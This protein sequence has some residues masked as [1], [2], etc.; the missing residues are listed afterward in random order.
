MPK[1]RAAL[2][3]EWH[4]ITPQN[5]LCP[6]LPTTTQTRLQLSSTSVAPG[7]HLSQRYR[8]QRSTDFYTELSGLAPFCTAELT[9]FVGKPDTT[10]TLF[11]KIQQW[12][13]WCPSKACWRIIQHN[14]RWWRRGRGPGLAWSPA[15]LCCRAGCY[16]DEMTVKNWRSWSDTPPHSLSWKPC[17]W[18]CVCQSSLSHLRCG[19]GNLSGCGSSNAFRQDRSSP[20]V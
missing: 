9:Q 18:H 17:V 2:K 1:H 3:H 16:T 6:E 15:C 10:T 11:I 8:L 7:V 4:A 13:D 20:Y 19:K 14:C 12:C 5:M